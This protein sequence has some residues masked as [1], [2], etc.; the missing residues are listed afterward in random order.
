MKERLLARV[1]WAVCGRDLDP[2]RLT[3]ATG[4]EPT[5]KLRRGERRPGK[6][7]PPPW[8]KWELEC[9]ATSDGNSS[10]VDGAAKALLALLWPHRRTL[11]RLAR[12]DGEWTKLE[13]W[14]EPPEL[15]ADFG[16][17]GP[18]LRKLAS[19]ADEVTFYVVPRTRKRRS[20]KRKS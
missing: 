16:S 13:I 11:A 7:I 6:Q 14:W 17:E 8:G 12:E 20:A 5:S 10:E 15:P 4:I 9:E 2:D 18:L 1:A 19:M 3:K